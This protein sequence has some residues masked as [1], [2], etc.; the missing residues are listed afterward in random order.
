MSE[1]QVN[2]IN[3]YTGANGVTIDGVLIKDGQVAGINTVFETWRLTADYATNNSIIT[4][5]SK[6]TDAPQGSIGTGL[7]DTSGVF[8]FPSTGYYKIDFYIQIYNNT[9]DVTV[10]AYLNTTTDNFVS[11]DYQA[12]EAISGPE[13]VVAEA[14]MGI[15]LDITDTSNQKFKLVTASLLAGSAIQ[16]DST[17]NE[18]YFIVQKISD[19]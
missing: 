14:S 13:G 10:A 16:G 3:E 19:T 18:T 4:G 5:W 17:Y 7:T 8:S 15:F 12:T 11:N 9:G 6:V 2:T 1:I